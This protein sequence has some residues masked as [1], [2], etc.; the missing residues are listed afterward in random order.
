MTTK[1]VLRVVGVHRTTLFRWTKLGIFPRRH[2]LGGWLRSEIEL[3]LSRRPNPM[4]VTHAAHAAHARRR[5]VKR[6]A[7]MPS[8][9]RPS[10]RSIGRATSPTVM[11]RLELTR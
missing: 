10:Q 11:R 6:I 1:Q 2:T 5:Q 7:P 4:L 8:T 9:I 3:W